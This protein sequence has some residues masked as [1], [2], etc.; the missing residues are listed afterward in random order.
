[1]LIGVTTI[2]D[3]VLVTGLNELYVVFSNIYLY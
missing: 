1:M 3:D 2:I